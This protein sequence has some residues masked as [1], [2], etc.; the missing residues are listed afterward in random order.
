MHFKHAWPTLKLSRCWYLTI[1]TE[2][3]KEGGTQGRGSRGDTTVLCMGYHH[4]HNT[5]G[6][7]CCP[8]C[9]KGNRS[10]QSHQAM[11]M[12]PEWTQHFT[13]R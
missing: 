12:E 8:I 7:D 1:V 4:L 13:C 11:W 6:D 10:H 2:A 3:K 9:R 5:Q